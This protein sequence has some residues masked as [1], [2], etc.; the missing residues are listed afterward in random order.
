MI[1]V[2]EAKKRVIK[3][4][5]TL[6]KI[7]IS[8][9]NCLNYAVAED[10]L[11]PFPLPSFRQSAMDGY[12]VNLL[13]N[14]NKF[15]CIG[16]IAAGS[17]RTD[18]LKKGEGVRIFTG[19][20]VPES[21]NCVIMQ[22]W[23]TASESEDHY[24]C[25][26]D[27]SKKVLSNHHIRPV[28]E[29]LL[30]GAIVL[31]KGTAITPAGI[32][33]L[34][35]FG[36]TKV[37]AFSRPKVAVIVTGDEL[38]LPN[39]ELKHGQIYESNSVGIIHTLEQKGFNAPSV[40]LVKDNYAELTDT[41]KNALENYDL[42]I[43]TG[44]ISVGKYDFVGKILKEQGVN[45]IFH[46]VK[47]KPGKPLFF[48]TKDKKIVFGLPGNPAASLSCLHEYV[49]PSIK[50]ISGYTN[51]GNITLNLPLKNSF[52][53]RGDRNKFLKAIISDNQVEIVDGQA[54]SMLHSFALA[55]CLVNIKG[56]SNQQVIEK[57]TLVEV[58]L[59]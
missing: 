18:N 21:A 14:T 4:S 19:A 38:M 13:E 54:S 44:G 57:G 3:N 47:Q 24:N 37:T 26:I 56:V 49:L 52:K 55:N 45:E 59:L 25:T 22:E 48:G 58:H 27:S 8:L 10:I 2:E 40:Y 33:L 17:S 39:E 9:D 11:A 30:K 50:K 29:Q 23:I 5:K 7:S 16:E 43:A 36:I 41:F 6:S 51:H 1:S 35:S 53:N 32:G 28:G 46:K 31:K 15:L 34:R 20:A 42:I 12:A